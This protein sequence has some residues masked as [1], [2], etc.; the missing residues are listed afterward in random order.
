MASLADLRATVASIVT[1]E[2]GYTEK[3]VVDMAVDCLGK[4]MDRTT[5]TKL[6]Q[7][8]LDDSAPKFVEKLFSKTGDV[9][10]P[11]T[12]KR[13][14][15]DPGDDTGTA[16]KRSI[17]SRFHDD[18]D[19]DVPYAVEEPVTTSGYTQ[20]Q[21]SD[22]IE[23]SK[24]QIEA[25]KQQI[26]NM[27]PL[28]GQ[29][30]LQPPSLP[31]AAPLPKIQEH[32]HLLAEAVEKA[33]RAAE[34]QAKIQSQLAN[35]PSLLTNLGAAKLIKDADNLVDQSKPQP[36][37]L[38]AEGRT[39]DSSGK[40]VQL[41]QRLPTLKA[42][43]RA[44]RQEQFKI[45][46]PNEDMM[47][48]PFFDQRVIIHSASRAKRSF[49]FNDKG[50][51]EQLGQKMRAKAQLEK[52]QSEISSVSK[53]SAISS[54]TRLALVAPQQGEAD[55][56]PDVE[57]WDSLVLLNNNYASASIPLKEGQD[58]FSRYRGI[59]KLIEHPIPFQPP[60]EPRRVAPIPILL[61]KK[62]RKKL[63]TQKRREAEKETQEKIQL[64]LVPP[65][66]PKVKISNLMRVLG[67]EAVQDPTK[68]EAHV[69]AQM[70]ERQKKHEEANAARKLTKD[71]KKTKKLKKMMEDTTLGVHVAVYRIRDISNLSN[72][73][74]VDMNAQQYH[75]TG[76]LILFKD[77]NLVVVEGGPK[78]MKKFKKLMLERIKWRM[79]GKGK[80]AADAEENRCDL[81]WQGTNRDRNFIDWKIK[82]VGA[83][84]FA[85]EHLKKYG[86]EHYW[87][88]ALSQSIVEEEEDD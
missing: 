63:R 65:P 27:A 39:I 5:T 51:Y 22:L 21:I 24:K 16:R 78:A 57:W 77:V 48:N 54:A 26:Q 74:K 18:D 86:V 36:L 85:R 15:R 2:L 75:L 44:K 3:A 45:Q 17:K 87:D 13:R 30:P 80:S 70:A 58:A 61:T 88:L 33:R 55:P 42:N 19:T 64:G 38:D 66:Q 35:R 50:K 11:P 34:L 28:I 67:S 83:E 46:R 79:P 68:V 81:V 8:L 20:S 76:C 29:T 32:D 40:T 4:G 69:R 43:I 72:K 84:V 9:K 59:S 52:L 56:I 73:F 6:M 53:K 49:L 23:N 60:N 82:Q 47:D 71:Q 1:D 14:F 41:S 31:A 12:R 7:S 37:I 10:I 62:E 25:R